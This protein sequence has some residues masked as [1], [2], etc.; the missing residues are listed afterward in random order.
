M[1]KI[2]ALAAAFALVS[3]AAFA[4]AATDFAT[5]DADASGDV[6]LAE[7]NT[8]WPDLTAELFAAA[9]TNADGKVDQAEYDVFLAA[10]PVP[11]P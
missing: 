2:L 10:N 9:D 1:K 8:I 7:A 4:Q 3:T 6:T 5:V 11:T